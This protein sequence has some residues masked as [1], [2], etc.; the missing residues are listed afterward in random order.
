VFQAH[1]GAPPPSYLVPV[2]GAQDKTIQ[3]FLARAYLVRMT[4]SI[5][6]AG[7]TAPDFTLRTTPDQDLSVTDLRGRPA[8]LV[9][10]PAD[11][12]PVCGDQLALYNELL[13]EFHRYDAQL[14]GISVDNT[15]SH[16]AYRQ[17]RNLHFPLLSDFE[18]KGEVA[19]RYGAYREKDGVA[20]RALFVLDSNGVIAWSYRSPISVNP[21]A[22][23]ILKALDELRVSA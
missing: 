18:P 17:Y 1:E 20:E 11:W 12:S 10:Y 8:I 14:V 4:S 6:P 21:G 13:E 5:L 9:F 7:T 22:D 16:V 19:R 2:H 23:G 15:W 3:P